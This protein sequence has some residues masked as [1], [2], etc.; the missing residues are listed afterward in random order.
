M[1]ITSKIEVQ[2]CVYSHLVLS[3][4][5]KLGLS[6]HRLLFYHNIYII[7]GEEN[8][9]KQKITFTR[10]KRWII[11]NATPNYSV[12]STPSGHCVLLRVS[13][14]SEYFLRMENSL[15]FLFICFFSFS[16]NKNL[17]NSSMALFIHLCIHYIIWCIMSHEGF[18][19]KH[20]QCYTPDFID[21]FVI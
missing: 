13:K 10:I 7:L 3:F 5:F 2:F 1:K 14:F 6:L 4:S 15:W 18:E 8:S 19:D 9:V 12:V 21:Y 20:T 17:L 11:L 16:R